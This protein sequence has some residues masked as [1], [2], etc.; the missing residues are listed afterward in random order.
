MPYLC[1]NVWAA[2]KS[3]YWIVIHFPVSPLSA[4]CCGHVSQINKSLNTAHAEKGNLSWFPSDWVCC[5]MNGWILFSH[6]C[7][8]FHGYIGWPAQSQ[9]PV[10]HKLKDFW[11]LT[12][13]SPDGPHSTVTAAGVKV[14]CLIFDF[15]VN[16]SVTHSSDPS[17][18][19]LK[20]S[21]RERHVF[22]AWHA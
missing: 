13:L 4:L 12:F 21:V 8:S 20:H 5:W 3:I 11:H 6:Q 19:H 16:L 15:L 10:P 7:A 18:P 17:W 14:I 1:S 2:S 9:W 22:T